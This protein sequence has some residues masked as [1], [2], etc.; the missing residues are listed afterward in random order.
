[1]IGTVLICRLGG[2]GESFVKYYASQPNYK[3][4]GIVRNKKSADENL[5]KN[6]IQNVTMLQADITDAKAM[7]AA[8]NEV[9]KATGGSLDILIPNAAV[10]AE[11]NRFKSLPDFPSMEDIEAD[12]NEAFSVNV[13]GAAF[14]IAAFLPLIRKGQTKKIAAISTAM[15]LDSL[16]NDY[17]LPMAAAYSISKAG[18]NT[19]I[20]KYNA[21]LKNENIL[22]FGI[23]PGY[24]GTDMN[25]VNGLDEEGL[26][27]VQAS[28]YTNGQQDNSNHVVA[29]W[30]LTF[31]ELTLLPIP[32]PVLDT[33]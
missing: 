7:L 3:V 27:A 11:K 6:G 8:A 9:S 1:L 2:I 21:A 25:D 14:T 31:T 16:T 32:I 30:S 10:A 23:S 33:C 18:M 17:S 28:T 26:Q 24:V 20:A 22:I 29:T 12:L 15:A 19:L 4:F 13:V 5:A